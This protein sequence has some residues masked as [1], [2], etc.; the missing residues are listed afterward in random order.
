MKTTL[1]HYHRIT[2]T[3]ETCSMCCLW[4]ASLMSLQENHLDSIT[5]E[6]FWNS[7]VEISVT[8]NLNPWNCGQDL[9]WIQRCTVIAN[10]PTYY[11]CG[12]NGYWLLQD[13]GLQCASPEEWKG[14]RIVA[15]GNI[16]VIPDKK[17]NGANVG[18]TWGRQDPSGSHVGH[19]N[20]VNW[21]QTIICQNWASTGLILSELWHLN[22]V[23]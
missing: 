14:Q 9:C 4:Q 12:I 2:L 11:K 21:D 1:L 22:I 23:L 8:A 19:M 6:W 7:I 13:G 20:L 5:Y 15:T 16:H 3:G 17:I 18:P 10:S